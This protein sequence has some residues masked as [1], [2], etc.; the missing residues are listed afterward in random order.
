[1]VRPSVAQT[2]VRWRGVVVAGRDIDR[3]ARLHRECPAMPTVYHVF[4]WGRAGYGDIEW[5]TV[6]GW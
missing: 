4:R 2:L 6:G 5:L 1:M 3:V